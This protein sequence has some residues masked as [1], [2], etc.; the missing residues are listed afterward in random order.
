MRRSRLTALI[1]VAAFSVAGATA[2]YADPAL[3]GL[4]NAKIGR[5]ADGSVIT[6]TGQ[7]VTP[8]GST[9]ELKGRPVDEAIRPDGKTAV[10]LNAQG[11]LLVVVDLA[12]KKVVQNLAVSG[13]SASFAGVA[14]SPDGNEV[15]A[16][17]ADGRI[18]R[19]AVAADGTL[20]NARTLSIPQTSGNPYP[21]GL[22]VA[23]DGKTLYVALSR[24][25]TLAVLD[26]ATEKMIQEIPVGNAPHAVVVKD[27]KAYVTN[28]AGRKA[29]GGRHDRRLRGYD[30]G[31]G[32]G[33]RGTVHRHGPWWIWPP[34]RRSGH[35]GRPAADPAALHDDALFVTNTSSDT[36]SAIDTGEP[37]RSRPS[38]Y[39]R[40][41]SPGGKPAQRGDVHRQGPA[42]RHPGSHQRPRHVPVDGL[43]GRPGVPAGWCRPAGTRRRSSATRRRGFLIANGKG[44]G[45]LGPAGTNG[46]HG[47]QALIGQRRVR[48]RADAGTSWASYSK[49]GAEEQRPQQALGPGQ[50]PSEQEARSG[51][52]A[53]RRAVDDQARVL[54]HQ[55]E[56]DLRPDP[57]RRRARATATPKLTEFGKDVTPNQ[58]AMVD[59]F[60][61]MD[62]FYADG[63]LSADGH[64]WAMQ[65]NVPDYL[66]KAFGSFVRSYPFNGGDSMAYLP[67]GFFWGDAPKAGKTVAGLR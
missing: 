6:S 2:A 27:G 21:G 8:A 20:S 62:N 50:G 36:I 67:T 34:V 7:R 66:E 48:D 44:V 45:A 40:S 31:G 33:D 19:A 65:A 54:H 4:G 5:Q 3:V 1:T 37:P 56:P 16:S 41:P 42:R 46:G 63:D 11:S 25:N 13:T 60:P 59:Q 57:R 28:Q 58:H 39:D 55:G 12:T 32:P 9:A 24:N 15:Y 10:L 17:S 26:L 22:A 49:T 51:A 43:S 52:R 29:Q 35:P 38:T 30:D 64:Q 53:H 47:V 18:V 23:P 14:Y 61:L